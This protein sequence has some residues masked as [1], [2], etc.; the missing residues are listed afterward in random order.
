MEGM[1]GF[2]DNSAI[3]SE[4]FYDTMRSH[5]SVFFMALDFKNTFSSIPHTL[6]IDCLKKEG[7]SGTVYSAY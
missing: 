2:S 6:V 1:N 4:I 3:I 5:K 7:I